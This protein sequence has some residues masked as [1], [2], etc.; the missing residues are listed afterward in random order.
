MIIERFERLKKDMLNR[1][2]ICKGKGIVN[3]KKCRCMKKFEYY[4]TLFFR[5][6]EEE[7]WDSTLDDFKGDKIAKGVIEDYIKNID[8]AFKYG[9]SLGLSGSHGVGK[10]LA[11]ILI[12]KA[13]LA[14]KYTIYFITLA[15]LLKLIKK[16]FSEE[17]SDAIKLYDE[18]KNIDFLA[19]DDLSEEYTPKDFGAFCVSEMSLLFRYRRRNCLPSIITT[20]LTKKDLENKYGSSLSSLMKS[21]FKFITI[22]GKD[23]REK[24]G[25]NWNKLLKSKE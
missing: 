13:A 7:Y 11:S 8:N 10:T 18:I 1:C 20:N 24:Q 19:L 4:I 17:D 2:K 12:L 25:K 3:N 21:N 6:I 15:E 16:P 23:F 14:K 22:S 5:G 9:L